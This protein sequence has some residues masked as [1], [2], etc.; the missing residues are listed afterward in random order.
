MEKPIIIQE[1]MIPAIPAKIK[2]TT[3]QVVKAADWNNAPTDTSPFRIDNLHWVWQSKDKTK[4]VGVVQP[5]QPGDILWVKE[6]WRPVEASSAGWCKIEYKDGAI[7]SYDEVIGLPSKEGAWRSLLMM[8]RKIARYLLCVTEVTPERLQKINAIGAYDEGAVRGPHF[9][10][11]GGER[12]LALHSRYRDDFAAAWN[13]NVS[14]IQKGENNMQD[15]RA[16]GNT[17]S[18]MYFYCGCMLD[19]AR[20]QILLSGKPVR[21]SGMVDRFGRRLPECEAYRGIADFD[22]R[23]LF[24][25]FQA[26]PGR[27]FCVI[28]SLDDMTFIPYG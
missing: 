12:C 27:K 8:P 3:R 7:L 18:K 5:V 16:G 10:S 21:V 23:K 13:R 28:T 19:E 15:I 6:A 17:G 14:D 1:D 25:L 4:S 20:L 9:V 2:T 26:G 22:S 24:L 11:Y